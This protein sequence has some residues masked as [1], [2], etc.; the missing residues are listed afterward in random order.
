MTYTIRLRR[1]LR[2]PS[3][4]RAWT[5]SAITIAATAI[6]AAACG[7]SPASTATGGPPHAGESVTSQQLAYARCVRSHGVPDFPDPS[8]T[9]GF[10]KTT[11]H[12]LSAGNSQYQ[13][14]TQS[15]AHLLP[16][17][18]SAPTTAQQQQQLNAMWRFTQCMRSHGVPNW[19]DPTRDPD[20]RLVFDSQSIDYNSPQ[21][22]TKI[23]D[24][25]HVFPASMGRRARSR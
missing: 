16:N 15:C 2:R 21:T 6:V 22:S 19:P 23:N 13:T 20:G 10:D 7:S 17:G 3:P 12:Q 9:G 11:L 25:A 5:A 8:S 1:Q 24:C 18:G 14:A 4:N